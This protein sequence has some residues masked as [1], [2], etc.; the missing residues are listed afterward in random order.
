MDVTAAMQHKARLRVPLDVAREAHTAPRASTQRAL[1]AGYEES[2]TASVS[3]DLP[4]G[5]RMATVT[6][7]APKKEP[8]ILNEDLFCAWVAAN[9]PG[10]VVAQTVCTVR[11]AFMEVLMGQI[12]EAGVPEIAG[13]G[14]IVQL[15]AGVAVQESEPV[16]TIK[17]SQAA[18]AQYAQELR[19]GPLAALLSPAGAALELE[20]GDGAA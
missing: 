1:D 3:Q 9:H 11:P 19:D 2:R 16:H 12:H 5:G 17:V 18:V 6:R 13:E 20:D 4:Q 14:G 7:N 15:V 10:E 8:K